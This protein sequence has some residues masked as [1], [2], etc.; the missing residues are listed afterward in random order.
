MLESSI[1]DR[2]CRQ[3]PKNTNEYM[4][5]RHMSVVSWGGGNLRKELVKETVVCVPHDVSAPRILTTYVDWDTTLEEDVLGA[6]TQL[7]DAQA[8]QRMEWLVKQDVSQR[9]AVLRE[10]KRGSFIGAQQLEVC[11]NP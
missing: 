9:P 5:L 11:P 2:H 10:E 4:L 8:S 7:R 3:L 6:S 1:L